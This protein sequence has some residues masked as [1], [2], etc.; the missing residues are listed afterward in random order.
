MDWGLGDSDPD[1]DGME[2]RKG[3]REGSACDFLF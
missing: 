3:S 2:N 1:F